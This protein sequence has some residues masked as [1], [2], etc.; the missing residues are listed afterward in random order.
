MIFGSSLLCIGDVFRYFVTA[1]KKFRPGWNYTLGLSLD[2]TVGDVVISVQI[3]DYVVYTLR[4]PQYNDTLI[5][6][7]TKTW[8]MPESGTN[9][10]NMPELGR[11]WADASASAQYRP[12]AGI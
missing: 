11:C 12:S 6:D 5:V 2:G 1:P 3:W 7:V 8:T 10:V 4:E 9:P